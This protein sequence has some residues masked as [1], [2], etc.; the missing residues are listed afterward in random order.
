MPLAAPE[1]L[2]KVPLLNCKKGGREPYCD[3][4]DLALHR[5]KTIETVLQESVT[6]Y[7]GDS[8]FNHPGEVLDVVAALGLATTIVD[9]YKNM[10][11]PMMARRHWIVHR[12]DRNDI[13]GQGQYAVRSIAPTTVRK[14]R[15]AVRD[16][17][18]AFTAALP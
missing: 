11:G 14:W 12:A 3:L 15:D 7:L 10:L 5:G 9:P 16:F 13:P 17:G 4:S 2:A 8:N 6:A 18:A 1:H